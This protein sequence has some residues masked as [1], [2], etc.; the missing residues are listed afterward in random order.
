MQRAIGHVIDQGTNAGFVVVEH[1]RISFIDNS[2]IRSMSFFHKMLQFTVQL[3]AAT[4]VLPF[5]TAERNGKRDFDVFDYIDPLIGTSN[6]GKT[7]SAT[8]NQELTLMVTY[9]SCLSRRNSTICMSMLAKQLT[10]I[11]DGS[12]AWQKQSPMSTIQ[13]RKREASHQ[14]TRTSMDSLIC[15]IRA[16][17]V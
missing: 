3:L 1:L 9:R 4:A 12:R 17:V 6:G 2:I 8:K 11:I 15:M 7:T 14:E 5:G 10:Q 13:T 16:L